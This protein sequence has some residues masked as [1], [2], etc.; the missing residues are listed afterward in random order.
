MDEIYQPEQSSSTLNE[1]PT[2]L[3][4]NNGTSSNDEEEDNNS[5]LDMDIVQLS[6][7][8]CSKNCAQSSEANS[9]PSEITLADDSDHQDDIT[10][11]TG[12][13]SSHYGLRRRRSVISYKVTMYI[14]T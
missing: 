7:R 14:Y 11:D 4:S 5:D 13:N 6:R 3:P 10:E 12:Q 2:I 8:S 1:L 9:Q